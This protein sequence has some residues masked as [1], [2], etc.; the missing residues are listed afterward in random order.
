MVV[1]RELGSETEFG[2]D[3][4]RVYID[5]VKR[6]DNGMLG[7]FDLAPDFKNGG[8]YAEIRKQTPY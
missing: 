7:S 2:S 8:I 4:V 6:K 5:K 3:L 1:V